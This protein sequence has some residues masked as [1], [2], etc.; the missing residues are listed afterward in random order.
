M[1]KNKKESGGKVNILVIIGI[2]FLQIVLSGV[3]FFFMS[4]FVFNKNTGAS[5]QVVESSVEQRFRRCS[6]RLF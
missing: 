4:K 3:L 6:K 2:I 1:A 5:Q